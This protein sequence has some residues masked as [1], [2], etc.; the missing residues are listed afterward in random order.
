MFGKQARAVETPKFRININSLNE[1]PVMSRNPS[2][3]YIIKSQD[4]FTES[5]L[6][7]GYVN[8]LA[9]LL[10]QNSNNNAD[11]PQEKEGHT[12]SSKCNHGIE[13]DD[14]KLSKFFKPNLT[15]KKT[16]HC[17]CKNSKCLK[18][19]CECLAHGEY[20]DDRCNCC[21][22]HN[23]VQKEDVRA[24]ALSLIMEK[25]PE[26]LEGESLKKQN[27]SK[28]VRGKGCNCKKSACLKKYCE[29]YN[30]GAGCGPH[31]KCEGC[32]N[33]NTR[34]DDS[35]SPVNEEADSPF[36]RIA[37]D[38]GLGLRTEICSEKSNMDL[39]LQFLK[40]QKTKS[41]TLFNRNF[42]SNSEP[43]IPIFGFGSNL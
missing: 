10:S 14:E 2:S 32:K 30:S 13:K 5:F 39:D 18:L 4:P 38:L 1:L 40:P 7:N 27:R 25:K 41:V 17:N 21:D 37:Q 34:V 42:N 29:C 15:K 12:H 31:C 22:C 23:N 3:D 26:I 16:R 19:Y 20:C 35:E 24:Y 28:I 43:S 8:L 9:S 36:A 6:A 33:P 11:S